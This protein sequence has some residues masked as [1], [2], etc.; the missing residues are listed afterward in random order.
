MKAKL[1]IYTFLS[2]GIFNSLSAQDFVPFP[3][4]SAHWQV[5]GTCTDYSAPGSPYM[6]NTQEI[7]KVGFDSLIGG[8][9]FAILYFDYQNPNLEDEKLAFIRQS[10]N[11]IFIKP[12]INFLY[13]PTE[14]YIDTSEYLFFD[15]DLQVG[16]SFYS[17]QPFLPNLTDSV[18]NWRSVVNID[19]IELLNGEYRKRWELSPNINWCNSN[20]YFIEGIGFGYDE[21]F[22]VDY[23]CL[24]P[25]YE[26][27]CGNHS[28]RFYQNE[29]HLLTTVIVNTEE[30]EKSPIIQLSPNPAVNSVFLTFEDGTFLSDWTYGIYDL[31]GNQLEQGYLKSNTI[32]ISQLPE[33]I[34]ILLLKN[35]NYQLQKK[36]V[37]MKD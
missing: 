16:E 13:A 14:D 10:G 9:H 11:K 3:T 8:N 29:E 33:G 34:Y 36:I 30:I 24:F 20:L 19:S 21:P 5:L 26:L 2:L 17:H 32:E 23:I 28:F 12:A 35:D 27:G 25:E 4:D 31:S 22:F 15:M 37:K 18:D 6:Y 7:I 1:L